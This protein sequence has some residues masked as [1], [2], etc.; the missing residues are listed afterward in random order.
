[1]GAPGRHRQASGERQPVASGRGSRACRVGA[2]G[3]C[4]L[5]L[6]H[7]K[8]NPFGLVLLSFLP[9]ARSA[10]HKQSDSSPLYAARHVVGWCARAGLYP[11]RQAN[12]FL[13]DRVHLRCRLMQAGAR[14][15][16]TLVSLVSSSRSL[17]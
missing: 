10:Q 4:R 12:A 9:F 15:S 13:A 2:A 8:A 17:A 11:P 7:N 16:P 5:C 3:L 6:S 14:S 1:M